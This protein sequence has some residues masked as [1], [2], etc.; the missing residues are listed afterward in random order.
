MCR[1]IRR[2]VWTAAAG[3]M[4]LRAAPAMA[5]G[6]LECLQQ[7]TFWVVGQL[8]RFL[9]ET[10]ADCGKLELAYPG[11][12]VLVD[13][14]PHKPGDTVQRFYL[15]AEKP[16]EDGKL[17]FSAG[18]Y[19][20]ELPVRIWPWG[21]LLTER[22][23]VNGDLQLPRM[24]PLDG[25]DE[26]KTGISFL[27]A[28]QIEQRRQTPLDEEERQRVANPPDLAG[29]WD[30]LVPSSQPRVCYINRKRDFRGCPICGKKVFQGRSAHYPW[31]VDPSDHPYKIQCPECETWFPSNDFAAGD[32]HSGDYPDDGWGYWDDEGNPYAFVAY[33]AL[34]NYYGYNYCSTPEAWADYFVRTGD[35]RCARVATVALFRI[36]EQ[37][38]NL[39]WNLN[40][41]NM[42]NRRYLWTMGWLQSLPP[43]GTPRD[44]FWYQSLYINTVWDTKQVH[45]H[46][47]AFDL[48]WDYLGKDDPEVLAFLQ[49][50]HHPEIRTMTDV[51]RFIEKGYL[52]VAAQALIDQ[53]M[54][55]N[56][57]AGPRAAVEA[58]LALNTPR[59]IDIVRWAFTGKG[60][61]RYFLTNEFFIDGSGFET[62][63]S[64]NRGHVGSTASFADL[65]RRVT[66]LRPE[67]YA[68]AKLPLMTTD[69][70]FKYLYDLNIDYT[71]I[72]RTHAPI[73]DAGSPAMTDPLPV[74]IGSA[75]YRGN[76]V[77]ALRHFPNEVNYARALWDS[78]ENQPVGEVTDPVMRQRV[79]EMVR[80]HG[81]Y[82]NLPSQVLDGYGHAILRAGK[83][84]HQRS[85]WVRYGQCYGHGHND[86][87][88]IG[89]EALQ[90]FLLPELGYYRGESYRGAWVNN[91]ANHYSLQMLDKDE[92]YV[93]G[94]GKGDLRL[95]ADG[96]WARVATAA[97]REHR[98]VDPPACYE[99]VSPEVANRERT[100]ALIDLSPQ[101]SYAVD[102]FRG[103]GGTQHYWSFHGPR[104]SAEPFGLETT[105]QKGGTLAGP[106]E[107]YGQTRRSPWGQARPALR[108]FPL[109]YDVHRGTSEDIWGLTWSLKNY[110]DVHLR[111]HA[112]QPSGTEIA[113]CKGKPPG[114]GEDMY[115]LQ[116]AIQKVTGP[117]PLNTQFITVL[118]A[119]E[120]RPL[121]NKVRRLDVRPA[122]G[123][124]PPVA[125]QVMAGDRVDTIIHCYDATVPVTTSNGVTMT[126]AFGVWSEVGGQFDR[127][128]LVAGTRIG[129]G[130]RSFTADAPAWSGR[131]VSTDYASHKVIVDTSHGDARQLIGRYARISNQ[132]GKNDATHQIVAAR[133]TPQGV[134]LTFQLDPRV[135]EGPVTEVADGA[136]KSGT[137][138]YLGTWAYYMGKTLTNEAGSA[139]YRVAGVPGS[140][141][142][143]HTVYINPQ[144]HPAATAAALGGQFTDADGDGTARFV[145]YDYGPGDRVTVPRVVQQRAGNGL[146]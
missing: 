31:I 64:Y 97:K 141:V 18:A 133:P 42:F 39:A 32:M 85:V 115:E 109:L 83:G 19:R 127:A 69:P 62:Q 66:D 87:L 104:G 68:A 134:E 81:L 138:L 35:R 79:T 120:G 74:K 2:F 137:N 135:G 3:S 77:P 33:Y 113:L 36:A 38:L 11:E 92:K 43:Q 50:R 15:R 9:I 27:T 41:R 111:L 116:W 124:Q 16:F 88:T 59:S 132:G 142:S 89:F 128:F 17:V 98:E 80:K 65:V 70:K 123:S 76:W 86:M 53:A 146:K 140:R 24:F 55:G 45:R 139:Q 67:Q 93:S 100:I 122:A 118:E 130:A 105:A 46:A 107:E 22:M 63:G 23:V 58:A 13:R 61:M 82:L 14:W 95:F 1:W 40:L 101:A 145:I 110:P 78:E 106:N 119:Y 121:I 108:A 125:L 28:E 126:G 103:R 52:R 129:R 4:L 91:W 84:E 51:R 117:E 90:R 54:L 29:L 8:Q 72:D 136:I 6:E 57:P 131:I 30:R 26:C 37:Y 112:V 99:L 96:G 34:W 56:R 60:E 44:P 25:K 10:P 47:K 75:L 7:P 144:L 20:F 5:A 48:L 21:K 12:L 143:R 73:G 94:R 102:I 49:A 114:G 71:L